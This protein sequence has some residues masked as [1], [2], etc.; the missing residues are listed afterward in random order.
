MHFFWCEGKRYPRGLLN[1]CCGRR[2]FNNT[3]HLCCQRHIH[4][5]VI[6][7][8]EECCGIFAFSKTIQICC[9]K[10]KVCLHDNGTKMACCG[11]KAFNNITHICSEGMVRLKEK[12]NSTSE[13][14]S[15][16]LI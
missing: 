13:L 10:T 4:L 2:A 5:I 1:D 6:D 3:T 11:E 14:I 16:N 9:N 12:S 8:A 7:K 15:F